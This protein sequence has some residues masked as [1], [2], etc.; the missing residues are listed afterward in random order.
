MQ[1]TWNPRKVFG[2]IGSIPGLSDATCIGVDG[3]STC[4]GHALAMLA[5]S[6]TI[7]D[8]ERLLRGVRAV[9]LPAEVDCIRVAISMTEGA[10]VAARAELRPGVREVALK[11]GSTRRCAGYGVN[12]PAIEGAFCATPRAH[13]RATRR[14]RS[15]SC[16]TSG[17]SRRR[18]RCG[19][20]SVPYSGYEGVMVRTWPCTGPSGTPSEAQRSLW[21]RWAEAHDAVVVRCRPGATLAEL[22]RA[23][24]DA[25]EQRCGL[26]IVQGVGLGVEQPVVGTDD[27]LAPPD[28]R[29]VAGMVLGVQGY[30]WQ[31][32]IGGYLGGETVHVTDAGPVRLTRLSH[33]PLSER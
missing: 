20:G 28:D 2:A 15:A 7:V 3:M 32:G 27:G 21:E 12:H 11:A 9:K 13:A 16:P 1:L 26:P 19:T 29:L 5:P 23:W 24:L 4:M 31:D 22:E 18:P 8:G 25:G 33:D 14:R 30:V 10:L 17:R 6:A